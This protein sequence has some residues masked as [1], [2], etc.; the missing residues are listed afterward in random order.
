MMRRAYERLQWVLVGL[1]AFLLPF[2]SFPWVARLTGSSMVAPLALL[3]L[4]V[5]LL[6]WFVPYL[7]RGGSLPRLS[8][9]LLAFGMA[10]LGACAAAFFIEIPPFRGASTA[11]AEGEALATLAVGL[12]FYLVLATWADRPERLRFVLR[13][14]NASG[15]LVILWSLAQVG[16][17]YRAHA[18]PDWM[19]AFQ[20]NMDTSLLLYAQRA[21]AFA[22]EPSW[23]AHQLNMLYLP[24][25]LACTATGFTAHRL[26]WRGLH[27]EHLLLLGGFVTLILS[28]SRIGLFTFLLMVAFLLLVWNVRLV[29]WLQERLSR[30]SRR[31]RPWIALASGLVLLAVYIGLAF[32]TGYGLSRYDARMKRLFDFST[33][34]EQSFLYYANQ[35]VFAE[36]V[37]FWQAGWEVFNDHPVLG[38]G[39]GNAGFFFRDKLS[40]FS[41]ALT[42][43]RV[44]MY[45]S[46]R[47]PNIKSLWV[48]LLAETGML[49][50]SLF[51]SWC[52]VLWHA[53]QALRARAP[54]LFRAIGLAGSF[55]LIGFVLEGFSLD[56]FALPYF[57]VTFALLTAASTAAR[58]AAVP[59]AIGSVFVG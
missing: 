34:R 43:V 1:L 42:E 17:W 49:G 29:R 10:A 40:A 11:R 4:I 23:L 37:V 25:W 55:A 3:P 45:Q 44:L 33:L 27:A 41:W 57:W 46:T 18:Y 48:R 36:R 8:L 53:A 26:H 30:K 9:P 35:L 39:L 5:L 6:V 56:T 21:N 38:V 2:S 14:V 31:L 59:I 7:L 54:A 24:L 32:G 12:C 28:V 51:I 52:Y 47:V 15:L 13:W 58:R 50:F 19:W 16:T 22:Y 20:G